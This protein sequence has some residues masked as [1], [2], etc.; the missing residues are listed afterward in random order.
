[1]KVQ[2]ACKE[3]R[4][5]TARMLRYLRSKDRTIQRGGIQRERN[6][7]IYLCSYDLHGGLTLGYLRWMCKEH[8]KYKPDEILFEESESTD[9]EGWGY[10][11]FNVDRI[12]YITD[13]QFYE[14]VKQQFKLAKGL[15][16]YASK[17]VE[18]NQKLKELGVNVDYSKSLQMYQAAVLLKEKDE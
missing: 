10:Q 1:M 12:G 13:V 11:E 5:E 15:S 18:Y 14:E 17:M 3:L 7:K 16:N 6:R 2:T 9:S 8:E 4:D